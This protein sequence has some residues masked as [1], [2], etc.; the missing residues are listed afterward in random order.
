MKVAKSLGFILIA[1]L[2]IA[3]FSLFFGRQGLSEK[4]QHFSSASGADSVVQKPNQVPDG[5][6]P[7][8]SELDEIIPWIVQMETRRVEGSEARV[9]AEKIEGKIDSFKSR[10]NQNELIDLVIETILYPATQKKRIPPGDWEPT[11]FSSVILSG[12]LSEGLPRE[13]LIWAIALKLT[14]GRSEAN[15]CLGE[16]L[17]KLLSSNPLEKL[18][19]LV[20]RDPENPPLAIVSSLFFVDPEDGIKIL[21]EANGDPVEND[22]ELM[23]DIREIIL[24]VKQFRW[25]TPN[26]DDTADA[27][28]MGHLIQMTSDSRW[29]MRAFAINCMG[30]S[31][32]HCRLNILAELRSDPHP[33]VKEMAKSKECRS[34]DGTQRSYG[35]HPRDAKGGQP[36]EL[37]AGLESQVKID[38]AKSAARQPDMKFS[39]LIENLADLLG[40]SQASMKKRK[41]GV[42]EFRSFVADL[43]PE[44]RINLAVEVVEME[45]MN[46]G[47]DQH[48]TSHDNPY[49][50]LYA[51]VLKSASRE[52]LIDPFFELTARGDPILSR[53]AKRRLHFL[54][55]P[56]AFSPFLPL[57]VKSKET[58]R[59]EIVDFMFETY[60]KNAVET[61]SEVYEESVPKREI[62]RLGTNILRDVQLK[63][64]I[65]SRSGVD[66]EQVDRDAAEALEQMLEDDRWWFRRFVVDMVR[67]CPAYCERDYLERL[68]DDPSPLVREAAREVDCAVVQTE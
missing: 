31:Q 8:L 9:L 38:E 11:Y 23:R 63:N 41:Q 26:P 12:Q 28:V 32:V 1:V 48:R 49:G 13:D 42:E 20:Q 29:W 59:Q 68:K 62:D 53:T 58:P 36:I 2:T 21:S 34:P 37:E 51:V 10:F 15:E 22:P 39:E 52:E 61:L 56:K 30:I 7:F 67:R 33:V 54:A 6:S 18:R 27:E 3:L 57:L 44:N 19:S 43:D 60:P 35:G 4:S 25:K 24:D 46:G 50:T 40:D 65:T 16:A 64:F 14:P 55:G 17:K 45:A 47:P 66:L 5:D